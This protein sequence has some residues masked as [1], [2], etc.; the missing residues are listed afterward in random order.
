[1]KFI[2]KLQEQKTE[3]KAHKIGDKKFSVISGAR[4]TVA[5]TAFT[6]TQIGKLRTE[7]K[8]DLGSGEKATTELLTTWLMGD[9]ELCDEIR[10]N[11]LKSILKTDCPMEED[12]LRNEIEKDV[13]GTEYSVEDFCLE[14]LIEIQNDLQVVV[15]KPSGKQKK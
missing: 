14:F 9:S 6:T 11:F 8:I 2:E 13:E 7:H 5:M 15:K 1:M 10:Y 12:T 3:V 4:L